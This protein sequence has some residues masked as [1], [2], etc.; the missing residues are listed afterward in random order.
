M[1][2][3]IADTSFELLAKLRGHLSSKFKT[4][5]GN[6]SN[7]S[8]RLADESRRQKIMCIPQDI[9]DVLNECRCD[10]P[11]HGAQQSWQLIEQVGY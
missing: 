4:H 7:Q 6:I 2:W 8:L 9:G 5:R 3:E 1:T 11:T 10:Q